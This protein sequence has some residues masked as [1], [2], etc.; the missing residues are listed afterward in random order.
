MNIKKRHIRHEQEHVAD[1]AGNKAE[2]SSTLRDN[3]SFVS[4]AEEAISFLGETKDF[5][6]GTK[7][8]KT[9]WERVE[10]KFPVKI[11]LHYLE[12]IKKE[13]LTGPLAKMA[14]PQY[15]ELDDDKLLLQDPLGE[16]EHEPIKGLIHRYKDRA[17]CL[18]TTKCAIY[19]RFCTRKRLTGKG[20]THLSQQ[21]LRDITE[22]LRNH[23]EIREVIISGGDPL[24]MPL[25]KLDYSLRV[26]KTVETVKIIRIGTRVPA[27]IPGL[28][29]QDTAR[30]LAN[31]GPLFVLTHFNHPRELSPEAKVALGRLADAG[32]PMLN[33]TV[34][35]SGINDDAETLKILFQELLTCRVKPYYLHQCDLTMGTGAF[36]TDPRKGMEIMRTLRTHLSGLAMPTFIVDLP[37]GRG[38][39][40]LTHNYLKTGTQEKQIDRV[41][42]SG[43]FILIEDPWGNCVE[44]PVL[45]DSKA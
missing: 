33:Q 35:L 29:T 41:H 36:R 43:N 12:L 23:S 18:V 45:K 39:V 11:P 7:D 25:D 14:L 9:T 5:S 26:I 28:I 38:K 22:Y 42:E 24:V 27:A 44:Y 2:N 4:S 1:A 20:Y 13:G 10:K 6:V 3:Q 30:V 17:L 16:H 40:P 34:L 31:H 32:L 21:E 8:L 37:G 15:A 19:C